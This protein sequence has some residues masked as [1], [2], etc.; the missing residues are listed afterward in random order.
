MERGVESGEIGNRGKFD[1]MYPKVIGRMA[2]RLRP[3]GYGVTRIARLQQ[4]VSA[5]ATPC[6]SGMQ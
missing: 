3:A 6:L 2:F 4:P 1:R 5:K